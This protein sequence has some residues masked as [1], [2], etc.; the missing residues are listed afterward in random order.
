MSC[1][2]YTVRLPDGRVL[3]AVEFVKG[4]LRAFAT[5]ASHAVELSVR[6][7]LP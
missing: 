2:R 4:P 7:R 5:I 6:L 1:S 3:R